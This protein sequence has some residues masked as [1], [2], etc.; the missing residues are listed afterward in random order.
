MYAFF[1]A[2]RVSS[3]GSSRTTPSSGGME[4]V[5]CSES[6]FSIAAASMRAFSSAARRCYLAMRRC[7]FS[8]AFCSRRSCSFCSRSSRST[9]S[10]D[11]EEER[12]DEWLRERL[13]ERPIY[14]CG[15]A[16][17]VVSSVLV[18]RVTKICNF[19]GVDDPEV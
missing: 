13:R 6:A 12:L 7:S 18:L 14:L 17:G 15:R 10:D 9:E 1:L 4:N 5:H 8:Y 11:D 2:T 16:A 19:G 3:Y